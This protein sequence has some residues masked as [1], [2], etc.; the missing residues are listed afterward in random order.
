MGQ[1]KIKNDL[2]L[3]E[4][5]ESGW[6]RVT[7]SGRIETTYQWRACKEH[8]DRPWFLC[9]RADGKGYLYISFRRSRVKAHRLAYALYTGEVPFGLEIN[10]L[11]GNKLNNTRDNLEIC[12]AKRQSQ[13]AYDTGLNKA[14]GERHY[15]SKLTEDKV[16]ELR[17]L[18]D[19]GVKYTV[20]AGK[21]GIT[22][23]AARYAHIRHTWKHVQ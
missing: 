3:K 20:L 23:A 10:H 12:D 4:M 7:D 5:L 6:F 1:L 21:F 14:V 8:T 19:I 15:R 13:H 18:A 2:V 17:E 16:K 9:D 22:A 11:D